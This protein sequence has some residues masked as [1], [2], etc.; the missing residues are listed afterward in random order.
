[1]AMSLWA[2][3]VAACLAATAAW[4]AMGAFHLPARGRESAL[5][6]QVTT[7]AAAAA[8][9]PPEAAALAR[10][11]APA[12][13]LA[14]ADLHGDLEQTERALQLTGAIGP[15]GRWAA[16]GCTLVQTGDLVDRGPSSW[17]AALPG[18]AEH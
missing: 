16:G 5:D 15:D 8:S 12:C 2:A 14:L 1:M 6:F 4:L 17:C 10:G 3:F 18:L 11:A 9:G 13:V 7:R